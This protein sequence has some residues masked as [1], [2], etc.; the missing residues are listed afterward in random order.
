M[1]ITKLL[2]VIW[3][4][5]SCASLY[6]NGVYLLEVRVKT[7]FILIMGCCIMQNTEDEVI[8]VYLSEDLDSLDVEFRAIQAI[9]A[10]YF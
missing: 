8:L 6:M 10:W 5:S 7:E 1:S 2:C 4:A 3:P 9:L